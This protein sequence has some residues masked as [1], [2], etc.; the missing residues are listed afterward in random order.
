MAGVGVGVGRLRVK[1][2]GSPTMI[3]IAANSTSTMMTNLRL[4]RSTNPPSPHQTMLFFV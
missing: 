3:T 2:A 1:P 4:R